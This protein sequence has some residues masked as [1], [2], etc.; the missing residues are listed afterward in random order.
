[1]EIGYVLGCFTNPN[2]VRSPKE[3][4]HL[5]CFRFVSCV[6]NKQMWFGWFLSSITKNKKTSKQFTLTFVNFSCFF[7]GLRF[8]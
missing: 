1:M 6:L 2:D 5:L 3:S 4:S 7:R 8:Y